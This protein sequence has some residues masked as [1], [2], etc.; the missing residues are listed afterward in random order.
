MPLRILILFT[1]SAAIGIHATE[2]TPDGSASGDKAPPPPPTRTASPAAAPPAPPRGPDSADNN[3]EP[4]PPTLT[5]AAAS[6][7][8]GAD[9]TDA[10]LAAPSTDDAEDASADDHKKQKQHAEWTSV[11]NGYFALPANPTEKQR[12][13]LRRFVDRRVDSAREHI[14]GCANELNASAVM[15]PFMIPVLQAYAEDETFNITSVANLVDVC[16]IATAIACTM[17]AVVFLWIETG[18]SSDFFVAR[19]ERQTTISWLEELNG[20]DKDGSAGAHVSSDRASLDAA[21]ATEK[22]ARLVKTL[23]EEELV[24]DILFLRTCYRRFQPHRQTARNATRV[25]AILMG[26]FAVAHLAVW[27]GVN[28][29][30]ETSNRGEDDDDI[31]PFWSESFWK[32]WTTAY[33]VGFAFVTVQLVLNTVA[34]VALIV[35]WTQLGRSYK[36]LPCPHVWI[37]D[38]NDLGMW[39]SILRRCVTGWKRVLHPADEFSDFWDV[40]ESGKKQQ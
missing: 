34:V 26:V 10:P 28:S 2:E 29:N 20:A 39:G 24:A 33:V 6:S 4:P 11:P 12:A 30:F 18:M 3:E 21:A 38:Q 15:L 37:G 25:G 13:A 5:P 36:V 19:G 17:W 22:R 16:V 9:S 7:A 23:K 40:V 8:W 31:D 35:T 32:N 14:N 1:S 27:D